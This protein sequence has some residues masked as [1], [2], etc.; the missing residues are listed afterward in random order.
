MTKV[1]AATPFAAVSV[2]FA[3]EA[4][5]ILTGWAPS[6]SRIVAYNVDV[7]PPVLVA[8]WAFLAG[9]FVLLLVLHFASALPWWRP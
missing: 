4:L 7:H 3:Y 6:I 8:V 5:A 2:F 1:L 9:M